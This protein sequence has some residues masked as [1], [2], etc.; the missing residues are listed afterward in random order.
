MALSTKNLTA[1][2]R[3]RPARGRVREYPRSRQVLQIPLGRALRPP[4]P[5]DPAR[6][7]LISIK[8][9]VDKMLQI[10]HV[11]RTQARDR[12][13]DFAVAGADIGR[14]RKSAVVARPLSEPV[15]PLGAV[16]LGASPLAHNGPL[17]RSREFGAEGAGGRDV[18]RGAHRDLILGEDLVLVGVENHV[19]VTG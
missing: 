17:V 9:G 1:L 13:G 4:R 15:E 11:V 10:V 18:V 19:V 6:M 12:A 3:E 5:P 14:A 8:L 7:L 2:A 16:G